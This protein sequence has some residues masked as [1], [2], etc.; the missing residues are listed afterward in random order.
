[1]DF[2]VVIVTPGIKSQSTREECQNIVII[3]KTYNP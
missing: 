2:L 3:V 1:M